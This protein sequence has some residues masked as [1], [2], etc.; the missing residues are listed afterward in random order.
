MLGNGPLCPKLAI[1]A[2]SLHEQYNITVST[3]YRK[4]SVRRDVAVLKSQA[5]ASAFCSL[6]ATQAYSPFS[7]HWTAALNHD[8]Y[9]VCAIL[10]KPE[11][12]SIYR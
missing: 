8:T 3:Q 5:S 11:L 12:K 4:V 10:L 2:T 1:D 7:V 6:N 9:E